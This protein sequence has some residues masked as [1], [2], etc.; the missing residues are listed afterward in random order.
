MNESR[1]YGERQLEAGQ[2]SDSLLVLLSHGRLLM[3]VSFGALVDDKEGTQNPWISFIRLFLEGVT[4]L[5]LQVV[6]EWCTGLC[7]GRHML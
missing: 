2:V 3:A 6:P 5:A 1:S 4:V 7:C